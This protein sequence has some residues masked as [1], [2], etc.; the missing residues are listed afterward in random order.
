LAGHL[1]NPWHD[2]LLIEQREREPSAYV[3]RDY[4]TEHPKSTLDDLL[5]ILEEL[6][7][8]DAIDILEPLRFIDTETI[9]NNKETD[10]V[11]PSYED[12]S[13]SVQFIKSDF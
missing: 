2:I 5:D 9:P 11:P 3:L 1:G 4:C 7:R 8:E 10:T 6:G 12:A 13:Y